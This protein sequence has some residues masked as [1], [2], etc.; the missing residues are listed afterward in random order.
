[1]MNSKAPINDRLH[2]LDHLRAFAIIFVFIFHYGRLFYAPQ[3][4]ISIGK[5]GWTGVDLFFV[6]SGYLIAS[7][8]FT[9]ILI[10]GINL[11][12]FFTKRIFRIIPVYLV[13]L[14]LYFLFPSL[15]EREAL[16]PLWKYLTFTQNIGLD[17]RNQGT[18]SH[19][20]SLCIEEQFYLL[21]PL[22]LWILVYFRRINKIFILLLILF[23][24]G[25]IF[26]L[27]TWTNFVSP[28]KGTDIFWFY[29]YKWIYYLTICR[30]DGLITGVLI[31]AI[32][33]F[34]PVYRIRIQPFGNHLLIISALV[35]TAAFYLCENEGSFS[36]SI[37]GFPLVSLGYGLMVLGALC[38]GS[39]LYNL[40]SRATQ[41]IADLSF[42]IYLSHKIV[43]HLSQSV[44]LSLEKD[45]WMMFAI[46]V[47]ATIAVAY[48]LNVLIEKPFLRVR[49]IVIK[50]MDF[51]ADG[52]ECK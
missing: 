14:L 13:I 35:L 50:R 24:S 48:V 51:L 26:R 21:F 1:M 12:I 42:A 22:I 19:A 20:W 45:S 25:F 34:K 11:R 16:A 37:F 4:L 15:R 18:F 39:L 23:L 5:F 29:W 27:Y 52:G 33:E 6:L 17:L 2:G 46:G 38:P 31:A 28:F 3:S 40:R 32:F 10:K 7:Q 41:K 49:N 43:L 30:L 36:A 9:G 47:L 8:L 44:Y